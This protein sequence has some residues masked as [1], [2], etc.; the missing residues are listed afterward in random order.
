M[1]PGG[2]D[3]DPA[4]RRTP[5]DGDAATSPPAARRLPVPTAREHAEALWLSAVMAEAGGEPGV[6]GPDGPHRSREVTRPR[7]ERSPGSGNEKPD[8]GNARETS[9]PDTNTSGPSAGARSGEY[10]PLSSTY[11]RDI[12]LAVPGSSDTRGP[13]GHDDDSDIL[14]GGLPWMRSGNE[15]AFVDERLRAARHGLR[16]LR[17][18]VPS[19]VEMMMD[20]EATA[21]RLVHGTGPVPVHTP[22]PERRWDLVL[23]V[24]DSP[25]MQVAWLDIVP[26]LVRFLVREGVFRDVRLR[27]FDGEAER[28]GQVSLRP[29]SQGTG[30]ARSPL[31]IFDP[32]GRSLIWVLTDGIG[33]GW[34]N[35][36]LHDHLWRWGRRLPVAV[37]N[38]LPTHL[39]HLTGLAPQRLRLVGGS[40]HLGSP[41]MSWDYQDA[42]AG[43]AVDVR[44]GSAA[45]APVPVLGLDGESITGWARFQAG[46]HD[47]RLDVSAVLASPLAAR[48]DQEPEPDLASND[49]PTP[50]EIVRRARAALSPAAF[51]LGVQLA[52]VPLTRDAIRMVCDLVPR[53]GRA[54]LGEILVQGLLRP[55]RG[56]GARHPRRPGEIAF[57]LDADVRAELLA[58]GRRSQTV[59]TWRSAGRLLSPAVAAVRHVDTVLDDPAGVPLPLIDPS[60]VPYVRVEQAVLGALSGRYRTR[61]Q[62]L[63]DALSR[64]DRAWRGT[65]PPDHPP[66]SGPGAERG[67]SPRRDLGDTNPVSPHGVSAPPDQRTPA[68]NETVT[69]SNDLMPAHTPTARQPEDPPGSAVSA[70]S[71]DPGGGDVPLSNA[72]STTTSSTTA[73]GTPE[74]RLPARRGGSQP[75]VWGNIPQR[76]H[77]FTGRTNLLVNL[78]QRLQSGTTAVLPEALHG[79]GGV[80]KSQ[81]AIEYVYRHVAD[82]DLVWW[83]PAERPTQISQALAELAVRLGLGVGQEANAAVPAV[84]EALRVGR[85]YGNWLLVF[86]NADE[87][88][89]VR[90]FFP[91]GGKGRIL[92]TSRNA[93]WAGAAHA[94]EVDVFKRG[95][96]VELL[97]RRM[98]S[99]GDGDADRLA[100][101]LGDLPLAIEQAATW[102]AETG[103]PTDEYLRLFEG[104]RRELL[105][106][107]PP[108]DYQ[109]PVRA[110]WNVSLDRLATSN[111]AALRL[112]QVCAY[113]APDPIPRQVFR[114]GRHLSIVPELD[115]ALRDSFKLNEAIREINR[116]AL[117][118]IDHRTN[119]LQMHRLVQAV[120]IDRMNP[121]ER[122]TMR[123]GAHSLLAASDPDEPQNPESW[124]VYAELYPHVIAAGAV[125]GHDPL[126]RDL[127]VNEVQYLWKWGDHQQGL[128][129]AQ[130][131]YDSWRVALGDEHPHTLAVGG[132][133][134]WLLQVV[135]DY[136]QA[137]PINTRVLELSERV[138]GP[139]HPETLAAF[140]NVTMDRKFSGDFT[141]AVRLSETAYAR[142]VNA[143]GPDQPQAL[144]A[145]HNLAAAVRLTGD[146]RRAHTID[147]ETWRQRC[148]VFGE[149]DGPSLDSYSSLSLNLR[150][151]GDYHGA[152]SRQE[153]LFARQR[154][155]LGTENHPD[156]LRALRHLAIAQR[157]AGN[158]EIAL[159][160]SRLALDLLRA[161]YGPDHPDTL[162]AVLSHSM[163]LRHNGELDEAQRLCEDARDRFTSTLGPAH[164]HT[165]AAE[166]NLAVIYRLAGDADTAYATDARV[167]D[168]LTRGLGPDHPVVLISATNLA[169]DHYALGRPEEARVLDEDTVTRSRARLGA[170]HPSTLAALANLAMDLRALKATDEA[171][172]LHAEAITALTSALS[173]EHPATQA[174]TS[175]VR[176]DCDIDP[177]PL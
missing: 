171:E 45:V 158:H 56:P 124:A 60:T 137:V 110:A 29:R 39:W 162:A 130:Q 64:A 75:A 96:S 140:A 36:V 9:P 93:Q 133:L 174:A 109:M 161:R 76:N 63:R 82:Y 123:G 103:M 10:F 143:Y 50:L 51:D 163:D 7:P 172:I 54:E 69:Q 160:S 125:E 25:S 99:V 111:P 139:N 83:I 17:Q 40:P 79:M 157:K 128:E 122:E 66:S 78:H 19:K 18:A 175:W 149:D 151:L 33:H 142:A 126:I 15:T 62:Q 73:N 85:P 52:A 57:E 88:R 136:E 118:R 55:V 168:A 90:D 8:G 43:L 21:E 129:L 156:V 31:E 35:G 74:D 77:N 41:G 164:P 34:R 91:T 48:G 11:D 120:L 28:P 166:T 146:F 86:D 30:A 114:R 32:T 147:D 107:A 84:I 148:L 53:A 94:L 71:A 22:A 68:V 176:S 138:H 89:T 47:R 49:A 101:A 150:E 113:F 115:A 177:M 119:S 154:R 135:G 97:R 65:D 141:G 1:T 13:N 59:R 153:D 132:W 61:A 134:G 70:V 72:P 152:L 98:I 108:L 6:G 38:P 131:A 100:D 20:E 173:L 37:L 106:T 144:N 27:F 112:L 44:A 92:I 23:L 87:P 121:D 81:L 58:C 24:D 167:F 67:E 26:R 104:K 2:A 16:F 159:E 3:P 12:V 5:G 46:R 102:L 95:E 127:L 80:G 170:E 169:S 117:A 165:L 14:W 116:Y 155:R 4:A 105:G 145:A 42:W